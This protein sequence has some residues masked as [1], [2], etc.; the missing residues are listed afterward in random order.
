[1]QLEILECTG[2]AEW[3]FNIWLRIKLLPVLVLP[4]TARTAN[5]YYDKVSKNC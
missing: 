3:L 4:T 2:N 5:D 1:M